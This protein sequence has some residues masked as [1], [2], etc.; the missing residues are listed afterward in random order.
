VNPGRHRWLLP[1]VCAVLPVV[2]VHWAWWLSRAAGYVPD[3][4]PHLEG[5]TSISRAARHGTGNTIFKLLMVPAAAVQAWHWWRCAAWLETSAGDGAARGLRSLGLVAGAAL[6]TYAI[7]LG[8]EGAVYGWLR[9]YG[10]VFYFAGTFL[11]IVLFLRGLGPVPEA[12]RWR[13]T[14]LSLAL[15]MLA[16]GIGSAFTPYFVADD[17]RQD[18]IR[19]VLEWWI[20]GLFTSWFL[21]NSA[22]FAAASPPATA[23][24][25]PPCPSQTR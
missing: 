7:F 11:A 10:I 6:A 12:A 15:A 18:A 24:G 13:R 1:L 22:F 5:C 4:I 9:R 19:D 25:S 17:L 8:T 21:L 20:G 14:M 23:P 3:C 2:A 16:L